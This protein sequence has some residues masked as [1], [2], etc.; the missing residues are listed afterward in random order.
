MA[1]TKAARLPPAPGQLQ[2]SIPAPALTYRAGA[3]RVGAAYA[4]TLARA[5]AGRRWRADGGD[6]RARQRGVQRGILVLSGPGR[7][8]CTDARMGRGP[9]DELG[10]RGSWYRRPRYPTAVVSKHKQA[11]VRCLRNRSSGPA[12]RVVHAAEAGTESLMHPTQHL[13]VL[14]RAS[15]Q[16]SE[17]R[18]ASTAPAEP[19]VSR[20]VCAYITTQQTQV[21]GVYFAPCARTLNNNLYNSPALSPCRPPVPKE[22]AGEAALP[23]SFAGSTRVYCGPGAAPRPWRSSTEARTFKQTPPDDDIVATD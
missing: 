22:K 5:E 1:P 20:G 4:A 10:Q 14:T 7:I 23:E 8:A 15:R 16:S 11:A 18:C 12:A 13:F 6:E 3:G 21:P 17:S 2:A 9:A 19:P